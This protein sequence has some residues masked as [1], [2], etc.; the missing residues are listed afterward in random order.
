ML[1]SEQLLIAANANIGV[2]IANFFPQ[3]GLTTFL[4]RAS[5]ELSL[6]SPGGRQHVDMQIS[7]LTSPAVFKLAG[8]YAL[9]TVSPRRNFKRLP[10]PYQQTVLTAFEE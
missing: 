10:P 2:S 1:Q 7:P 6:L 3:I 5:P 9:N 4:G 8:S